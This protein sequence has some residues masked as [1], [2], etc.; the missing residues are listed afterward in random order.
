MRALIV[1]ITVLTASGAA[2]AMSPSC[3]A[4]FEARQHTR[5]V[6]LALDN[7]PK[8]TERT[9]RWMELLDAQETEKVVLER[10]HAGVTDAPTRALLD[11][12]RDEYRFH[13]S[14]GKSLVAWK[15]Q[16]GMPRARELVTEMVMQIALR[17]YEAWVTI[18]EVACTHPPEKP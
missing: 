18:A 8:G 3:T 13:Q 10:T 9:E 12:L 14:L 7:T 6:R 15:S 2:Y 11:G 17:Q 1:L 5:Y 16:P 4:L